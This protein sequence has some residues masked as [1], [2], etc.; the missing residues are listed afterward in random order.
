ML[1]QAQHANQGKESCRE[2]YPPHEHESEF[3]TRILHQALSPPVPPHLAFPRESKSH[4]LTNS[5]QTTKWRPQTSI[6]LWPLATQDRRSSNNVAQRTNRQIHPLKIN[7]HQRTAAL[8][9][10]LSPDLKESHFCCRS[11]SC[12]NSGYGARRRGFSAAI[13]L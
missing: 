2:K 12:H 6:A 7:L 9:C 5:K 1:S 4:S 3:L 8:T 11:F 13:T 10:Q